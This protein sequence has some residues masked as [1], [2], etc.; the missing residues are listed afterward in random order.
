[1]PHIQLI[2][3]GIVCAVV[4]ALLGL[5]ITAMYF[6]KGLSKEQ[7]QLEEDKV[8]SQDNA[9][10]L[11]ASAQK[12]AE[13]NKRDLL[14]QAKE[15]VSRVRSELEREAKE[16][17]QEL[18]KERNKL[19]Q[20]E[21]NISRIEATCE[22]KQEEIEKKQQNVAELEARVVILDKNGAPVAFLGDNPDRKKW[23]NFGVK[24]EDQ[25]SGLFTAPHGLGFATNG[26]LYVQDWNISGRI[27]KLRRK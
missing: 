23:A 3:T 20:K 17:K 9:S 24:P 25:Q 14:L 26:D 7:K 15:E 22:R 8:K 21:E 1:M 11:I 19:E 18:A 6:K 27:T 13:N 4:G 5:V 2:V 10:S 16:K 12:E